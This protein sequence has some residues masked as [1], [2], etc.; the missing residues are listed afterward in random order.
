MRQYAKGGKR[1]IALAYRREQD[2]INDNH[3]DSQSTVSGTTTQFLADEVRSNVER[4]FVFVGLV[5]IYDPPREESARSVE[6]CRR[7]GISVHMVKK[8]KKI[9][10]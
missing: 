1:V 9:L 6:S 8:K 10:E 3:T 4:D 5:G 2:A 7:A